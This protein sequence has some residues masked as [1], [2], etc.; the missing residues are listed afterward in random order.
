[1]IVDISEHKIRINENLP[2]GPR[3]PWPAKEADPNDVGA[4]PLRGDITVLPADDSRKLR[5][6]WIIKEEIGVVVINDAAISR[7]R[8]D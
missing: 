8:F 4:F 5:I 7:V 6:G 2:A 3:V 1:M